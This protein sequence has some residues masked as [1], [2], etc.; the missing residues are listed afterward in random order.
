[1][2]KKNFTLIELLVVIA[3]IAIL[4]SM[5]LPALNQA[6]EKAVGVSCSA[7]LKQ[8]SLA[9]Q[10]YG[11]DNDGWIYH[12]YGNKQSISFYPLM[13]K[14]LNAKADGSSNEFAGTEKIICPKTRKL[15]SKARS[16][17]HR[18]YYGF[19]YNKSS[20]E[21]YGIPL[22]RYNYT[23]NGKKLS[24]SSIIFT[25]DT[26]S[27]P[28]PGSAWAGNTWYHGN[29][30][31][32]ASILFHHTG[33]ANV[34]FVDGHVGQLSKKNIGNNDSDNKLVYGRSLKTISAYRIGVDDG[35]I[36]PYVN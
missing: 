17:A 28:W 20:A 31:S 12:Y 1:M 3:I 24:P 6:R 14:Y 34:A 7:Q 23:F 26:A 5:L 35:V 16:K 10:M 33:R 36:N 18:Y 15:I 9:T 25:G 13:V 19:G 27:E 11:N 32:Y 30:K 4:A 29:S 22:F 8:V 21:K 2:K